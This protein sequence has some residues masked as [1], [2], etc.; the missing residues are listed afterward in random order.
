[1]YVVEAAL[2]SE[3]SSRNMETSEPPPGPPGPSPG[4]Q[5]PSPR[6]PPGP[7]P[8]GRSI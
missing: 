4:P 8:W 7:P 2:R 3:A 6:P 1:M 5:G